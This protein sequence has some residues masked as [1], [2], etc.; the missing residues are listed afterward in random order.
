M[1]TINTYSQEE[2][3][4]L[5]DTY[6]ISRTDLG[7]L[8]KQKVDYKVIKKQLSEFLRTLYAQGLFLGHSG[9]ITPHL[10]RKL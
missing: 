7:D 2:A 1:K 8:S 4:I 6:L 9:E 3:F 10:S 5:L